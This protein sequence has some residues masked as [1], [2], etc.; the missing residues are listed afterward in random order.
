MLRYKESTRH[1][2]VDHETNETRSFV[3]VPH[4]LPSV[5]SNCRVAFGPSTCREASVMALSP[6]IG[7]MKLS[8]CVVFEQPFSS[9]IP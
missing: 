5:L 6:G 7:N 3:S 4:V 2:L 9:S 1:V 8:S